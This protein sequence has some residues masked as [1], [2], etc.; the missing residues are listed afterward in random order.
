MTDEIK[1]ANPMTDETKNTPTQAA[2]LGQSLGNG[3]P[4][5]DYSGIEVDYSDPDAFN[6]TIADPIVRDRWHLPP[7]LR[8]ML[9][10]TGEPSEALFSTF[11]SAARKLCIDVDVIIK[12]CQDKKTFGDKSSII[13]YVSGNGGEACV[14]AAIERDANAPLE[15]VEREE[16]N[17]PDIESDL[18][19][20]W[21]LTEAA[22]KARAGKCP[23]YQR[24]GK[25]V[26]PRWRWVKFTDNDGRQRN[27]LTA[28]IEEYNAVQLADV[29]AHHAVQFQTYSNRMRSWKK[30]NPPEEIVSTLLRIKHY[31]LPALVGI[32]TSPTL[33]PDLSLL[34]E[35]GYD[36]AT[37]LWYKPCD[38]IKLPDIAEHPSR[39]DAE[40]GLTKLNSLLMGFPFDGETKENQ[41]S[42]SRSAALAAIMTTCARGALATAVP[43]FVVTANNPRTGKTYL[44][45]TIGM[46]ATGHIPIPN[47]GSHKK[48]EFEKRIEAAAMIGRSIMHFNNLPNGM[49]IESERLSEISTEGIIHIR[50]LGKHEQVL[51]DCRATTTFLNGNNILLS[52]DLIFRAAHCR[53]NAQMER[54]EERKFADDPMQLIRQDRGAYLAAVFSIIRAF[55]AAGSP[56]PAEDEMKR[57]AGFEQWS[58]LIQQ[59]LIWLGMEDPFGAME[60]MAGMDPVLEQL[61]G[62]LD[63]L[64]KYQQELS[65]RFT[66]AR[67]MELA[68][69]KENDHYG[70]PIYKYQ[71]LRDVM[72]YHGKPDGQY[73]GRLLMKNRDKICGGWRITL[74]PAK[75]ATRVFRLVPP[76]VA[77]PLAAEPGQA[78]A[79]EVEEPM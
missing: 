12:A 58:K 56:E 9:S 15:V 79:A 6:F 65:G 30:I 28:Q 37:G 66:V 8:D 63:V 14:K 43:L 70:R 33:R 23:V 18:D 42:V 68:E 76:R 22:L 46:I 60:E 38:D 62:L 47:S 53:L 57:V 16:I 29:I 10:L 1:G 40:A 64:K 4:K 48:E 35:P 34:T 71:D 17:I 50:R 5:I 51:C 69:T 61:Q 54:P 19:K 74:E 73:F 44:V 67:C 27:V 11:I 31:G 39:A 52:D 26:W 75:R 77:S 41:K 78:L 45:N 3:R 55:R 13:R 59:P 72:S 32:A 2:S 25:L 20:Y 21:R 49:V 7:Q 24:D 36:E